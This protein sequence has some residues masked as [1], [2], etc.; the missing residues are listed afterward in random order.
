MLPISHLVAPAK[1]IL[2]MDT[3]VPGSKHIRHDAV[4][5]AFPYSV[6]PFS[7][8]N[9]HFGFSITEPIKRILGSVKIRWLALASLIGARPIRVEGD[10][11]SFFMPRLDLG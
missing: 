8:L 10:S 6:A 1:A 9:L 4:R 7:Y 3:S 5:S 11:Y 2:E